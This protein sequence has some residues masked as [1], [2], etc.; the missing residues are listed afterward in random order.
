MINIKQRFYKIIILFFSF[1]IVSCQTNNNTQ[2]IVK[3]ENIITEID[4][5][6]HN[7]IEIALL[8]PK[9]DNPS[10][11]DYENLIKMGL[12][13]GLKTHV[14]ITSY[15]ASDE[16]LQI[17]M[18]KIIERNTK[19]ILGPIY[20]KQVK[21]IA[22]EAKKHNI[23]MITMSNDPSV[24]D[25]KLFVFGH[26]PLKELNRI[27]TYFLDNQYKN[28]IMFLPSGQYSL[29]INQIVQ[30]MLIERNATLVKTIFY[31][32]E[33]ESINQAINILSNRVDN[34]NELI[35]NTTKPV[36]YIGSDS[37]KSLNLIFNLLRHN[38]LDRKAV[39]IGDNKIDIDYQSDLSINFTGSLNFLSNDIVERAKYLGIPHLSFMHLMS[40]DLGKMTAN[41][42]GN[43]FN[44]EQF[45]AR[46]NS[47]T[48]YIGIS[49]DIYFIDS[50]AQ[51][52]YDIIR[53]IADQ[54]ITLSTSK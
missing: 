44:E 49:G 50:I 24:A 27:L 7:E 1:F 52:K 10:Y 45:L 43:N 21:S 51:R 33:A 54:Y 5:I 23:I 14:H 22:N 38:H 34:L 42:I 32:S 16:K 20:S 35:E 37:N 30:N 39:I 25:S 17:A 26:A 53:K 13:D 12:E 46:M 2:K 15:D 18:S 11:K 8:I 9:T 19:I 40:Y 3:Q 31:T 29:N 28:F 4:N 47:Q 41:Y 36:I 6:I 48:P